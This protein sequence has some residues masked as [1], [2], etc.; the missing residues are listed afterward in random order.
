MT[1]RSI[2]T[3]L[4]RSCRWVNCMIVQST[5]SSERI[6]RVLGEAH[7]SVSECG[8]IAGLMFRVDLSVMLVAR[9]Y[10]AA[11]ARLQANSGTSERPSGRTSTN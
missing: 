1:I 11:V 6:D 9:W 10:R 8:L 7:T 4:Q 5:Y 3:S 2:A